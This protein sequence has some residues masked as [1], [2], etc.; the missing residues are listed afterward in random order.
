MMRR[1]LGL[2]GWALS[3]L[4]FLSGTPVGHSA[5]AAPP[6]APSGPQRAMVFGDSFSWYASADY[7]QLFGGV[8]STTWSAMGGYT[9][10]SW[11]RE[12]SAMGALMPA[13]SPMV[14]AL[15]SNDARQATKV[16]PIP[17]WTKVLAALA[18]TNRCVVVPDLERPDAARQA[19]WARLEPILKTYPNV[20]VA[21]WWTA[22]AQ[23]HPEWVGPDGLHHSP[24][25]QKAYAWAIW[26][27]IVKEC[28]K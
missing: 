1:S 25:G 11:E 10:Q 8:T 12:V 3:A 26:L 20:R 19:F 21:P 2:A 24:A 18:A 6:A 23:Y 13:S 16:D 4:L 28:T 5:P 27:G 22:I 7:L 14:L 15:G 9:L 17:V